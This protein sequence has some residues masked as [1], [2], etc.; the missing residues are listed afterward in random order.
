MDPNDVL[1]A[2]EIHCGDDGQ[3]DSAANLDPNDL[4][5]GG[6]IMSWIV[7]P[8]T[9]PMSWDPATNR[10]QGD[11]Y[12]DEDMGQIRLHQEVR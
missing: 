7:G 4:I 10:T 1:V 9:A 11:E 2:N 8:S 3:L 5:T 12:D 6:L